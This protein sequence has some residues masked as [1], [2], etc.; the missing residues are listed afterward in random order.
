MDVES[1]VGTT[2]FLICV[3]LW[4]MTNHRTTHRKKEYST[5]ANCVFVNFEIKFQQGFHSF[6][7]PLISR[8]A[9]GE[10]TKWYMKENTYFCRNSKGKSNFYSSSWEKKNVSKFWSLI[11]DIVYNSSLLILYYI[12]FYIDYHP[13]LDLFIVTISVFWSHDL[14]NLCCF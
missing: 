12:I 9:S 10:N 7:L 13:S 14:Y 2:F 6:V 11:N 3:N 8:K 1:H 4:N 5:N